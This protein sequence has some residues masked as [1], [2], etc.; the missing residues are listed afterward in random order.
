[1]TLAIDTA[2][3]DSGFETSKVYD[4]CRPRFSRRVFAI[5]GPSNSIGR[6]IWPKKATRNMEKK[7]DVFLIGLD[8]AKTVTQRRLMLTEH[9][10]GYCH[11]PKNEAYDEKYF[12]GLT[13]EKAITKYKFGKA[14]KEWHTPDGGRNEPWDC[15]IYAYAARTSSPVNV[16]RRLADLQA[17]AKSRSEATEPAAPPTVGGPGRRVRSSG[18]SA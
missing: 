1:V 10:A 15:R 18:V 9:G 14:Y 13:I 17:H 6:P 12:S 8:N 11:F 5:K 3:V 4:F 16:E 2:C 7:T